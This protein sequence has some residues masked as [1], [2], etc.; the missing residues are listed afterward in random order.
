MYTLCDHDIIDL[1][2][3]CGF[4]GGL[5]CINLKTSNKRAQCHY[6]SSLRSLVLYVSIISIMAQ[7]V[8]REARVLNL[9]NYCLLVSVTAEKKYT[10]FNADSFN[11]SNANALSDFNEID[12]TKHTE[13]DFSNSHS[14]SNYSNNYS[15]SAS[16]KS[17][18][19]VDSFS[20]SNASANAFASNNS[21]TSDNRDSMNVNVS[22]NTP[23]GGGS[24]G[25]GHNRSNYNQTTNSLNNK[26]SNNSNSSGMKQSSSSESNLDVRQN[27]N[28]NSES[29][30]NSGHSMN[31]DRNK[32]K[33]SNAKSNQF[34]VG[35]DST[36]SNDYQKIQA[37]MCV[38]N[39]S[40]N[41][42]VY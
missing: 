36:Q 10:S 11:H 25:Y 1:A 33:S 39:I 9:T 16:S 28:S 42:L 19:N 3:M 26:N 5:S 13:N 21:N 6:Y 31:F 12:D 27:I 41:T 24:V 40:G 14:S 8:T 29:S 30:S 20:K 35:N 32:R 38:C 23:F 17:S 15:K 4:Q 2:S 34:A 7:H 37:G 18:S 22:V